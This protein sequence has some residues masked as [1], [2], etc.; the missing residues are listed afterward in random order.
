MQNSQIKK[1]ITIP[2]DV[3]MNI[4][5]PPLNK[6]AIIPDD[7]PEWNLNQ[8]ITLLRTKK[9]L[10]NKFLYYFFCEGNPVN[11]LVNE[12]RGVVGQVNISLSQCRNFIIP[13]ASPEEQQEIVSRIE[14]LFTKADAIEQ[15]YKA[16]KVSIDT[17]PQALLHNAF[18]GELTEQLDRDG[19]ARELLEEIKVL[20]AATGK[21]FKSKTNKIA[22]K[23]VKL[24]SETDEI[25]GMVAEEHYTK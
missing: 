3:I 4:V 7:Y 11:K 24:Y 17:L 21:A 23:K 18:E 1:S 2:G 5:G 20:K 10:S 25:L 14:S 9:Y 16:L 13:I 15:Q 19:D 22:I 12:T 6:I 8:A